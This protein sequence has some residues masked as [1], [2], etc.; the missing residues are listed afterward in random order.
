VVSYGV[1]LRQKEI[2]IRRALGASRAS[3]RRLIARQLLAPL[4]VATLIGITIGVGANQLVKAGNPATSNL[5]VLDPFAMTAIVLLIALTSAISIL[6]PVRRA[7]QTD[8]IET[9][10]HE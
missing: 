6:L 7:L 1:T 9:L 3:I 5:R 8:V 10:R 4:T 2:G